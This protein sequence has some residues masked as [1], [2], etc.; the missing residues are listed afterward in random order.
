MADGAVV[1]V[2]ALADVDALRVGDRRPRQQRGADQYFHYVLG[3]HEW[4]PPNRSSAIE[5]LQRSH[6]RSLIK[7][8]AAPENAFRVETL[9]PHQCRR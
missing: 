2:L 1:V 7:R 4:F 8:K 9:K 3:T 6:R 5:S